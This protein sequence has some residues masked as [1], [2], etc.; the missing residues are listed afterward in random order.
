MYS[1]NKQ[2][3]VATEGT[4]NMFYFIL[5]NS[6]FTFSLSKYLIA[7]NIILTVCGPQ[8]RFTKLFSF[9]HNNNAIIYRNNVMYMLY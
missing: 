1:T 2:H 3:M 4:N 7:F 9:V 6:N 5:R 8:T